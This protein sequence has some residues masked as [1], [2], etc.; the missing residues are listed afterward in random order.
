MILGLCSSEVM[1][2]MFQSLAAGGGA[3]AEKTPLPARER[4]GRPDCQSAL[5][6]KIPAIHD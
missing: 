1:K 6:E 3:G 5:L 4:G 2:R